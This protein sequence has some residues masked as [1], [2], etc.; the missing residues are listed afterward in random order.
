[1]CLFYKVTYSDVDV[2]PQL[3]SGPDKVPEHSD[4]ILRSHSASSIEEFLFTSHS[5]PLGGSPHRSSSPFATPRAYG[6]VP[7]TS[8]GPPT[9][10]LPSTPPTP[11][12]LI[13]PPPSP[14]S[15]HPESRSPFP[16]KIG[17]VTRLQTSIGQLRSPFLF[18]S[19]MYHQAPSISAWR[20]I[21]DDLATII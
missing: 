15:P 3:G 13:I 21:L 1:V 17:R 5:P 20:S 12:I 19:C 4:L 16:M 7:A 8:T 14:F 10:R 18:S 11:F 2:L 9:R 6:R